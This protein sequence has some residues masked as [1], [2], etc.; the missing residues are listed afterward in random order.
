MAS[1]FERVIFSWVGGLVSGRLRRL[2]T[3]PNL[4]PAGG[5]PAPGVL[6]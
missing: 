3:T 1:A 4:S 6:H 2:E 5:V